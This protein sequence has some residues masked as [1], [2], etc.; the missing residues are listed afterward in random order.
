MATIQ[1]VYNATNSPGGSEYEAIHATLKLLLGLPGY[2]DLTARLDLLKN[3]IAVSQGDINGGTTLH[4]LLTDILARVTYIQAAVDTINNTLNGGHI[5]TNLGIVI[6]KVSSMESDTQ[7]IGEIQDDWN[8]GDHT[9]FGALNSV[10][11]D[12]NT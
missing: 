6:T 1:D 10:S 8:L 5:D 3:G 11:G 12:I 4:S 9:I 2:T 7:K